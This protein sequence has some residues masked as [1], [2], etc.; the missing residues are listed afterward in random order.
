MLELIFK[1]LEVGGLVAAFYYT[2]KRIDSHHTLLLK[3]LHLFEIHE[4]IHEKLNSQINIAESAIFNLAGSATNQEVQIN[5]LRN[6][7]KEMKFQ[8]E[9]LRGTEKWP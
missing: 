5:E 2:N 7:I 6:Q 9:R 8:I 1:I 4:E 3:H